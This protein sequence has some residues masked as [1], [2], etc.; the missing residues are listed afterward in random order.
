PIPQLT[1]WQAVPMYFPA[2]PERY[3]EPMPIPH[4]RTARTSDSHLQALA[5]RMEIAFPITE[6]PNPAQAKSISFA[7]VTARLFGP[8]TVQVQPETSSAGQS[9]VSPT[10][11]MTM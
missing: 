6:S 1:S 10:T 3:Y 11:T 9:R 2:R 4:P 7:G 8:S 5:I